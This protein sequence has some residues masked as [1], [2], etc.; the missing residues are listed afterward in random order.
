MTAVNPFPSTEEVQRRTGVSVWARLNANEN[1]FGPP[2]VVRAAIIRA[3]TEANR[4]PDCENIDLK[5]AL[6]ATHGI[7]PENIH[8]MAGIDGLLSA[9]SRTR[10]GRGRS[11]AAVCGTYPTMAY[12]ARAGGTTVHTVPYAGHRI[13]IDALLA[14]AHR[15]QPD[16]VYL[17][18]PDNPT[19]VALGATEVLRLADQLPPRCTLVVDG[20]YADYQTPGRTLRE[21]DVLDR[22]M[23]WLRTFSKAYGMAGL[24]VGYAVGRPE[25]LDVLAYGS[26]HYAVGRIAQQAALAAVSDPQ[27]ISETVRAT[28]AGRDHYRTELA[29]DF[30]VLPGETNF[31]SLRCPGGARQAGA[32][33]RYLARQGV[34]VRQ[35]GAPGI[36]DLLRVTIGPPWQREVVI[37]EFQRALEAMRE[38]A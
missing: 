8:V 23:L 10:L 35:P 13:G 3:A 33:Q 2:E 16:V 25:L 31:V 15:H 4:Y 6:A 34:L 9:V 19:G 7:D 14:A 12:L 21:A 17:A 37:G 1:E 5:S 11:L 22:K 18:E 20:A 32:L 27:T 26:E 30:E 29:P 38:S 28:S 24:R 36:D